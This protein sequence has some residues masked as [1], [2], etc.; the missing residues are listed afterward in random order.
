MTK[1][2]ES[3]DDREAED[4][5]ESE[6]ILGAQHVSKGHRR[7]DRNAEQD[8][9]AKYISTATGEQLDTV[10]RLHGLDRKQG[11]SDDRYRARLK[12]AAHRVG[13]E[14]E[15]ESQDSK[16]EIVGGVKVL[17]PEPG[18]EPFCEWCD[19]DVDGEYYLI[20]ARTFPAKWP[21]TFCSEECAREWGNAV[22]ADRP[23]LHVE[24]VR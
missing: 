17:P 4:D 7:E 24:E 23:L 3:A 22:D 14:S 20:K 5:D 15:R 9:E 11:E 13:T 12:A 8:T 16:A 18:P 19:E 10:G 21:P 6:P 2:T 1:P